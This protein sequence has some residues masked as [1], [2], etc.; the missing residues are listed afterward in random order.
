MSSVQKCLI[1]AL[2]VCSADL[3]NLDV[4]LCQ[5]KKVDKS[6]DEKTQLNK[7]LKMAASLGKMEVVKELLKKGADIQWRD[8]SDNGKTPLVKAILGGRFEVVKFL[9]ESGADIHY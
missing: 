4:V 2:L 6:D 1:A 3:L 9:I 5:E 8:P 7:D